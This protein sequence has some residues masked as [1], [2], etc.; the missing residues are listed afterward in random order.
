MKYRVKELLI[1]KMYE[2]AKRYE[3]DFGIFYYK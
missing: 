3:T 1:Y 2:I